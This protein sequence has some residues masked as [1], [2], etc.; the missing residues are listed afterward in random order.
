MGD[1][2]GH[3]STLVARYPA[4]EPVRPS[5]EKAYTLLTACYERGGK[6]LVCGNGGSAA[7]CEH[8]VGELMKGFMK[9]R[10]LDP[11][12]QA[13]L[14]SADRDLGARLAGKLQ[15][16]LA[17]VSL[18]GHPALSSAFSN[19]VDPELGFAQALLGLASSGDV[20]LGI[21]TSGNARNV[22]Y[23]LVLAGTLGLTTIGLTGSAG[24]RMSALCSATIRVPETETYRIQELHLPVYH[25]LC[26]MLEEHFFCEEEAA[27]R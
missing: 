16:P 2:L 5:I 27:S 9:P 4:L 25:A 17:A 3:L 6:L 18:V 24:G 13:A 23:A 22:C 26:A 15:R 10:P 12:L 19:D 21:S 14:R 1:P 7:D 20:L 8:I 11:R